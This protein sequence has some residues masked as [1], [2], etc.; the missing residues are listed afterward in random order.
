MGAIRVSIEEYLLKAVLLTRSDVM[1]A[2]EAGQAVGQSDSLV[3]AGLF[4]CRP[5]A[6]WFTIRFLGYVRNGWQ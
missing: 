5:A 4:Q 3:F 6:A 1:L 2:L